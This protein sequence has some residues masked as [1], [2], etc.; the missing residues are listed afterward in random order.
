VAVSGY[1]FDVEEL[2]R[3]ELDARKEYQSGCRAVV[4][5]GGEDVFVGEIRV[6]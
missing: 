2:A 6:R 4:C 3:I 1:Q 5:Y